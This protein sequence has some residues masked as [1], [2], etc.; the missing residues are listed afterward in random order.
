MSVTVVGQGQSSPQVNDGTTSFVGGRR[1]AVTAVVMFLGASNLMV[2]TQAGFAAMCNQYDLKNTQKMNEVLHEDNRSYQ[3]Y[4]DKYKN[5]EKPQGYAEELQIRMQTMNNHSQEYKN[6]GSMIRTACDVATQMP[7][8]AAQSQKTF[9]EQ[10]QMLV[11]QNKDIA[12]LM[13]R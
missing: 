2:A 11:S 8:T 10:A 7:T 3:E 9:L 13:G 6:A 12:D 1:G 5:A 4:V